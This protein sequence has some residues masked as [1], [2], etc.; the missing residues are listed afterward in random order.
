MSKKIRLS[1]DLNLSSI[2]W[3]LSLYC[4]CKTAT[5]DLICSASIER[6]NRDPEATYQKIATNIEEFEVR[7]ELSMV[8]LFDSFDKEDLAEKFITNKARFHKR[9]NNKFSDLKLN[10]VKEREQKRRNNDQEEI[11]LEDNINS[12]EITR[13]KSVQEC[14]SAK[15]LDLPLLQIAK[16]LNAFS[17]LVLKELDTDC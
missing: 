7:N 16:K 1:I 5:N 12:H 3:N 13:D 2:D 15:K 17:V 9:C 14:S 11:I 4:Q 6:K 8:L 10:R